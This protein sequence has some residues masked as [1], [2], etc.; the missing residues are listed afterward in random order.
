MVTPYHHGT[1]R[2]ALLQAAETLLV[3]EGLGALTL[4]ATAREAG[5][6]HAAPAHHFG[7]L[8]GLLSELA[9]IGFLR[10]HAF[11]EAQERDAIPAD[12]FRAQ[13][14]GYVRFASEH[15]ALFQLMFRS[16]RLDWTNAALSGAGGAAFALLTAS[17]RGGRT[18]ESGIVGAMARWSY[19]HGLASLLIDGRLKAVAD[20][21]GEANVEALTEALLNR[22]GFN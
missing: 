11:I 14:R 3:R 8:S 9:S 17:D 20:K 5:V 13:M 22:S 6:S 15:P 21:F 1:L 4:R 7:D 16:E 19:V 2:P 10:L 12:R 18:G